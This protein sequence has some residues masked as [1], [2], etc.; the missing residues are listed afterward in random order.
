[1]ENFYSKIRNFKLPSKKEINSAFHSFSKKERKVFGVLLVILILSTLLIL[2]SVNKTFLVEVPLKGGT[3][4]IGTVG[5]PRFINP[6]L[7]SSQA[8]LDLVTLIYSGL[9]RKDTKGQLIPDLAEKYESSPDGLSYT[10][11]LK[12]NLSFHNEKPLTADD[13]LFTIT[14]I[15]D[16]IVNSPQ[17]VSWDGVGVEK[18]DERTIRF[19]LKQPYAS[20]LENTTLGIMPRELWDDAPLE[21][22]TANTDPI[23]SGPYMISSIEKKDSGTIDSYQL[24]SFNKFALGRPHIENIN[25]HFYQN[26][27]DMVKALTNNEIEESSPISPENANLLKEKN[28]Q[29]KPKVLPRVFGL[30]FNQNKNQIFIDKVVVQ[31]I[32]QAIDKDRIVREV[33]LGYGKVIDGPIPPNLIEYQTLTNTNQLGRQEVLQKVKSDLEKD[34][35]KAGTDGFLEKTT[36]EKKQKTTKK[37]EFSIS[38]GNVEELT[39]AA[40][41][42]KEDLAAVGIK[43]EIKTF[44]SGNLNKNVIRPREYDALLFGEIIQYESDLFAFWHSSQRKDPG[45]NVAM[46]TNAKVDKLLEDA[47]I[48]VD[49][50]ARAKKY[51]QFVE[52]VRKDMPAVFLYSPDSIAVVSKKMKGEE[53]EKI[54]SPGD[55]YLNAYL[56]YVQTEKVW[57]VFTK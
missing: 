4:S 19:T 41:L 54:I 45:L 51:I 48:T 14:K 25:M 30:F 47:S 50:D 9:M 20:F 3:V 37:L 39:K 56:W 57:K 21:L 55:R 40:E 29:I 5:V 17:K 31:A 16:S 28:Y 6:V 13:V 38:T 34:G 36:T 23:G 24:K 44:E 53:M 7:A 1:M 12:E 32:D 18:L 35:W 8:D 46:Y 43:A 27:E 33:L 2:Q 11:T 15:K 10:F 52:E 49:S 26:E 42:I 22:N